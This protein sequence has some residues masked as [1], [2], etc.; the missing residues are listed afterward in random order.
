[1]VQ[2]RSVIRS[3]MEW[4]PVK[5]ELRSFAA[6]IDSWVELVHVHGCKC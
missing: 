1:M 3:E 6:E 5:H 4:Q 2:A